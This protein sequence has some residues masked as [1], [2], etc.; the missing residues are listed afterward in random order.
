MRR[1]SHGGNGHF[2]FGVYKAKK[3]RP[4]NH[5]ITAAFGSVYYIHII[6]IIILN[7][8]TASK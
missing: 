4:L 6:I 7:K 1:L 3:K 8:K 5:G 2:W